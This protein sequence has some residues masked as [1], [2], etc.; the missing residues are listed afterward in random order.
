MLSAT[1]PLVQPVPGEK[2]PQG[3]SASR[4]VGRPPAAQPRLRRGALRAALSLHKPSPII[5]SPPGISTAAGIVLSI[6]P[7]HTISKSLRSAFSRGSSSSPFLPSQHFY[8]LVG[9]QCAFVHRLAHLQ[10]AAGAVPGRVQS[11]YSG[12]HPFIH[13]NPSILHRSAQLAG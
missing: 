9:R 2:R 10:Q 3:H 4:C 8:R 13:Y 5:K 1:L 6:K 7:Y 11:R 12:L